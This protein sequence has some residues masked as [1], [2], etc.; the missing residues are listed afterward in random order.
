M[1]TVA[2]AE[3][4]P[5]ALLNF[6]K[7]MVVFL[8]FPRATVAYPKTPLSHQPPFVSKL[9]PD[10]DAEITAAAIAKGASEWTLENGYRTLEALTAGHWKM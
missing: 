9:V 4:F 5:E 1:R 6:L 7:T 8:S 3:A 10:L 2:A